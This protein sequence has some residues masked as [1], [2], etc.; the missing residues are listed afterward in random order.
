M[1]ARRERTLPA[2]EVKNRFGA[3]LREVAR[4]GGP[5]VITTP[6]GNVLLSLNELNIDND[7]HAV[8][9]GGSIEEEAKPGI[10]ALDVVDFQVTNAITTAN[11]TTTFDDGHSADFVIDLLTGNVTPA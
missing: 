2:T 1:V 11:L 8:S 7:G 6:Q 5:I 10:F 3:V 9:G 4:T